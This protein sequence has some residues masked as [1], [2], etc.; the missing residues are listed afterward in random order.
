L[1]FFLASSL[2]LL[3]FFLFVFAFTSFKIFLKKMFFFF[4]ALFIDCFLFWLRGAREEKD[5]KATSSLALFRDVN[6]SERK[7]RTAKHF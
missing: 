1:L 6:E 4:A 2:S 3:L 7:K 5:Q